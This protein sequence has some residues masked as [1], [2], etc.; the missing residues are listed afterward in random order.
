MQRV[1]EASF[2]E[3]TTSRSCEDVNGF[4]NVTF[5]PG[6]KAIIYSCSMFGYDSRF[7]PLKAFSTF[8][9]FV[10]HFF[11]WA[12]EPQVK[13]RQVVYEVSS[14]SKYGTFENE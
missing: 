7:Q 3:V 10:G 13:L 6:G 12:R 1:N 11:K 14:R 2:F 5:G 8:S 4:H 9:T